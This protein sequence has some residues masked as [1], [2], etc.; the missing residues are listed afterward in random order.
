MNINHHMA[1]RLGASFPIKAG[2]GKPVGRFIFNY[3]SKHSEQM[4]HTD[5]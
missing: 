2:P 3:Y 1:V 4:S 5:E